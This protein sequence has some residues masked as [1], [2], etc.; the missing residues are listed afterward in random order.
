M[1]LIDPGTRTIVAANAAASEFYGY[2]RDQ[3]TGMP[4][5]E[6]NILSPEDIASEMA[7][8]AA[9]RRSYFVFPHR[10]ASGAIKTVEVSSS[11]YR[12]P[13]D[14]RELLL[15]VIR[16][17]STRELPPEESAEYRA[18]LNV[19]AERRA[20][21]LVAARSANRWMLT[22]LIALVA[23]GAGLGLH[24]RYQ[25]QRVRLARSMLEERSRLYTELQH[26]IKNSFAG[27]VSLIDIEAG[28]REEGETREA[29]LA[30]RGRVETLDALY[31]LMYER[32]SAETVDL[33]AYLAEIA[34]ALAGASENR[35][36]TME[37][38]SSLAALEWN[39]K[40]ASSLGLILNEL[41]TNAFKHLG[42]ERPASIRVELRAE[43]GWL[44]IAVD[45]PG[46]PLPEGFRPESS[47]GFGLLLVSE[48]VEQRDG[49]LRFSSGGGRV[50]F[51]ARIPLRTE[52]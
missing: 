37:F 7:A 8:A 48:L 39:S 13:G 12:V 10:L 35:D 11:P 5:S 22:A 3:L 44:S 18:R 27:M 45:N 49:E 32:G 47:S 29:L 36:V 19:L 41:A 25:R 43:A 31:K 26:R 24:L 14:E 15:S 34:G 46:G 30:L 16:D 50:A 38:S 21:E 9:E 42:P 1:L 4:V 40:E 17:A 23:V 51:V 6:L 33:G 52:P 2:A 28:R 20:A